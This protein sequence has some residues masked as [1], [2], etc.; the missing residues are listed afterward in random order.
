MRGKRCRVDGTSLKLTIFPT[1]CARREGT[2]RFTVLEGQID[3]PQGS[4]MVAPPRAAQSFENAS[5]TEEAEIYMTATPGMF[6]QNDL[7]PPF[8]LHSPF[9]LFLDS[10]K[11]GAD[12]RLLSA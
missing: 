9:P 3:A 10:N 4:M 5:Q 8:L 6:Y 11:E 12:Y 2:V 7:P 1:L